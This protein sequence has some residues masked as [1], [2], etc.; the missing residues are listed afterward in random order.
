MLLRSVLSLVG[1]VL[2]LGVVLFLPAG[3]IWWSSGWLFIAYF[4]ALTIPSI[5]MTISMRL[6]QYSPT[7]SSLPTPCPIR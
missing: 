4:I 6:R 5:A 7:L 1:F 3:D 2:F